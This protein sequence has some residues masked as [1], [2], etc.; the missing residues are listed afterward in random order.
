MFSNCECERD[1]ICAAEMSNDRFMAIR[2]VFSSS[3][4]SK[5]RFAPGFRP[6]PCWGAYDAPQEP[7]VGWGGGDPLPIPFPLDAFGVLIS[8]P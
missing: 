2:C 7:L 5:T 4:Y 6:G 3:K 8:A 1:S